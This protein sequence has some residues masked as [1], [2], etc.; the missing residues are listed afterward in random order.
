MNV[1]TPVHDRQSNGMETPLLSPIRI[2]SLSPLKGAVLAADTTL[3]DVL[4]TDPDVTMEGRRERRGG[5]G[6]LGKAPDLDE[7]ERPYARYTF[8]FFTFIPLVATLWLSSHSLPPYQVDMKDLDNFDNYII[9]YFNYIGDASFSMTGTLTA[10]GKGMDLMGCTIIG[11]ITALGGGTIRD[12]L[13]G[14]FPIGWMVGYDE[15]VLCL[16][17]IFI[18][19]FGWQRFARRFG[20]TVDQDWI[21]FSDCLGLGVFTAVGAQ[22]ADASGVNIFGCAICGMITATGGGV[23]R[24]V[25]CQSRPRIFYST[26]GREIYALPAL[27]GGFASSALL[28]TNVAIGSSLHNKLASVF[29]G[30]FVTV[31]YRTYAWNAQVVLPNFESYSSSGKRSDILEDVASPVLPT[32]AEDTEVCAVT[33]A[34]A[35]SFSRSILNASGPL[36]VT[37]RQSFSASVL[38]ASPQHIGILART[39]TRKRS[40][41]FTSK[42]TSTFSADRRAR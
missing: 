38:N 37:R 5:E 29:F 30:I 20:L 25:L 14:R 6:S 3:G 17:V 7:E 10:G 4:V 16:V 31:T 35:G 42:L 12:V 1:E 39:P 22:I 19:F 27:L 23:I 21:F 2:S 36:T 26:N 13:L 34:Q 15:F 32:I 24:D 40:T 18:T 9:K 8:A 41:S 11:V 28:A 33:P